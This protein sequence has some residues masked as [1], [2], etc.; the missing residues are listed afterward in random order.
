M[1]GKWTVPFL[2]IV[3][4]WMTTVVAAEELV[5]ED[6]RPQFIPAAQ[7]DALVLDEQTVHTPTGGLIV[8]QDE[9]MFVGLYGRPIFTRDTDADHPDRYHSIDLLYDRRRGRHHSV[10]LFSAESDQPVAGGWKTFQAASVW[11]YEVFQRP[12]TSI[13]IGGGLAV[14]DFGIELDDGTA[15]PLIPVPFVRMHHAS[16]YV[17][18]TLDFITGPNLNVVVAPERD[19]QFTADVRIDQFRDIRDLIFETTL[20]YRFLAAGVKNDTFGFA[21]ADKDDPVE[22]HYRAAFGTLDLS[23]LKITGG[24]AFDGR[25]RT[26]ESDTASLGDGYFVSIQAFL[27]L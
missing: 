19:L 14:S 20:K 2:V 6:D 4:M 22:V 10:S 11:G 3:M 18:A 16:P 13:V 24:Y 9:D 7:Y 5:V 12:Q 1:K 27:P 15:W 8:L 23:I 25:K 17:E 21:P 26:G